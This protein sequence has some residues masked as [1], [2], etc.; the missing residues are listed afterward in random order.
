MNFVTDARNKII[1]KNRSK[2]R[3]A[4]DKLAEIAKTT[5]ARLKIMKKRKNNP[6][7][8]P[9]LHR[10]APKNKQYGL[11]SNSK[12]ARTAEK[13]RRAPPP[14]IRDPAPPPPQH[15]PRGRKYPDFNA[16]DIDEPM[17]RRTVTNDLVELPPFPRF[18]RSR[19][20]ERNERDSF[21]T[22]DPFD[23]YEVPTTR[24]PSNVAEPIHIQRK[25]FNVDSMHNTMPKKGILRSSRLPSPTYHRRYEPI[26]ENSSLSHQMRTRL[27]R[28]PNDLESHGILAKA[29]S[30]PIIA[31]GYRIVVSNLHCSVSQGD[32]KELFEDIGELLEARLVRPGVAEVIFGNLR[33]ADTAVDTY[34]N[35]HLDGQ[36][37]KCLLVKPRSSGRPTSSSH[38]SKLQKEE[39]DIDALH[40]ALFRRN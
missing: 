31:G 18:N 36:P 9:I 12:V 35:R 32:I 40:K 28:A 38:T 23:C 29:D 6:F 24:R 15:S 19:T 2:I 22:S 11:T 34:H 20:P 17:I 27:E 21:W 14:F 33:D 25:I 13:R 26:V 7:E 39:V 30:P 4:R 5:D 1:Q 10:G 3:D 8:H 37:M 16:M